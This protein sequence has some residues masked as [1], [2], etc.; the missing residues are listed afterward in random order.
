MSWD[1]TGNSYT[2][3]LT[4][5]GM[6]DAAIAALNIIEANETGPEIPVP[7]LKIARSIADQM[8]ERRWLSGKQL[9]KLQT[10]ACMPRRLVGPWDWRKSVSER[11]RLQL[12]PE[13]SE[14]EVRYRD[15]WASR[16]AAET[17]ELNAAYQRG[18][19]KG[20]LTGRRKGLDDSSQELDRQ[21]ATIK[22]RMK[23]ALGE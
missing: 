6:W 16:P 21:V 8:R 17:K 7:E 10:I 22:R 3:E 15:K 4:T 1:A 13:I 14:A 5:S 19:E 18:H 2:R 12:E 11:M 9:E 20:Y 23:R